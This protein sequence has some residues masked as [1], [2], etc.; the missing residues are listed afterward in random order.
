MSNRDPD[1]RYDTLEQELRFAFDQ[2]LKRVKTVLPGVVVSYLAGRAQVRPALNQLLTDGSSMPRPP[3]L[4]V[5]V[6]LQAGGGLVAGVPLAAGDPV[7][8]LYSHRDIQRFKET[9]LAGDPPTATVFSDTD[10]VALPGFVPLSFTPAS[11]TGLS[12]QTVDG[13]T[14]LIV[15]DGKVTILHPSGPTVFD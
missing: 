15:E 6:M 8:L 14:A 5:P 13:T 2:W 4:D 10:V 12:L 11:T 3:V 7:L 1:A 9:L